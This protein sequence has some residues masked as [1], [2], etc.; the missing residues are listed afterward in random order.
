MYDDGPEGLRVRRLKQLQ[1]LKLVPTDIVPAPVVAETKAWKEMSEVERRESARK[2]EVYAAMVDKLDENVGRVLDYLEN[3]GELD[4]TFVIFMSDNGAEGNLL[5]SLPVMSNLGVSE[6]LR[7]YYDNSFDNIAP[8][9]GFKGWTTE[10]GIRC[11]CIIRHPSEIQLPAGSISHAYLNVMDILPTFLEM[12]GVTHA[13]P[14]FRG[15]DVV[16]PRGKSWVPMLNN[17]SDSVYVQETDTAGWELFGMRA[18]RRGNYKAVFVPPPKGSGEWELFDL[19]K[20]P[21]ELENL[22]QSLPDLMSQMLEDWEVYFAETGMFE[23]DGDRNSIKSMY[24]RY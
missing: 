23:P 19:E 20:D 3:S 4:D 21:G 2:M 6:T 22:A 5:E 24:G 12:A 10:G 15:R 11:P 7:K 8:S 14:K 9:R 18:M 16:A 13:A 1:E 17:Q